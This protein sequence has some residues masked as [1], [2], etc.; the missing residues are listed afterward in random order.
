[1]KSVN[2]GVLVVKPTQLFLDWLGSL[3]DPPGDTSLDDLRQDSTAFL[4]SDASAED[5]DPWL[6]RN[7]QLLFEAELGEWSTDPTHWPAAR[8]YQ[9]FRA[10]FDVEVSTVVVDLA[11]GRI[12]H[13]EM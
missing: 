9:L 13:E 10:W 2:R 6:R 4:V 1:M 3:P 5:I 8:N 7:Y 11:P 12:I